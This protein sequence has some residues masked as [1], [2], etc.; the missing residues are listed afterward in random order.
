MNTE[1][2]K[3]DTVI[4]VRTQK[5]TSDRLSK[6]SKATNRSRSALVGEALEQYVAHQ[7]WLSA[8][9]QRGVEAADRGELVSNNAVAAWIESLESK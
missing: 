1:G 9:I 3:H 5:S 6:L 2:E 4:S 8:E 7:D